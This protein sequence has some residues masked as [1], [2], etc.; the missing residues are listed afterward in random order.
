MRTR[1]KICGIT[2]PEDARAAALLGAD[3]IGLVFYAASPRA[4]S[5]EQAQTIVRTLPAFVTVVG[6]FVDAAPAAIEQVLQSV[7][8]DTLQFHGH[9]PAGQ[10][11]RY[12]RPYIKVLRMSEGV[13]VAACARDYAD[14]AALLLDTYHEKIAG[15]MGT[16]FDWSRVPANMD[17]PIIL[18][19]GLA[20]Q[21]VGAAVRQVRPYG[22]D[23]SG[24]VES[25]Q[26]IK[27]AQKMATFIEEVNRVNS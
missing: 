24:G 19:G 9:E 5:I 7:R 26:G 4:V 27:D 18:A 8:I 22:V 13:D 12:R 25:A 11:G 15:G 2:R 1:V 10:C 20:P 17:K 3:A 14:A 6:L 21:N 16:P 23:V